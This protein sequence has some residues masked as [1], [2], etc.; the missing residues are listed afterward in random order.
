MLNQIV[1][2]KTVFDIKKVY[3]YET[4]LFEIE[5]LIFTKMEFALDYQQW[6]IGY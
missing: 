1:W 4:E 6:L 3:L 5:L 2:N